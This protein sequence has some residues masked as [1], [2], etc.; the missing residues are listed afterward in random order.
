MSSKLP[1][2]HSRLAQP[3]AV[4][5]GLAAPRLRRHRLLRQ[6]LSQLHL[7]APGR[8]CQPALVG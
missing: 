8:Q 4:A 2:A 5:L 3:S 7:F 1:T 6:L